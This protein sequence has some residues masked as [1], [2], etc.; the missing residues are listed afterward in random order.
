VTAVLKNVQN[1]N[2]HTIFA[3]SI[4][5]AD[6]R[7]VA[8]ILGQECLGTKATLKYVYGMIATASI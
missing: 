3:K 8:P 6:T 4:T 5:S 2:M 1:Q 7:L